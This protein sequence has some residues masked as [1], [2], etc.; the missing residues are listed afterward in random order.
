MIVEI[1]KIRK[2]RVKKIDE[3]LILISFRLYKI[4]N[5]YVIVK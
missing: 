1:N 3:I 5:P 2:L 4:Y